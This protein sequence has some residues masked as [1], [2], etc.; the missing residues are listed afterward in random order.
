MFPDE[1][2]H[3]PPDWEQ[4]DFQNLLRE[5]LETEAGEEAEVEFLGDED[6]PDHNKY[7]DICGPA[8]GEDDPDPFFVLDGLVEDDATDIKH[9]P[10]NTYTYIFIRLEYA[11]CLV[12]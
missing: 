4:Q 11:V 9:L 8:Q 2:Y 1:A 5:A 3:L 10:P 12:V 7:E 6:Q